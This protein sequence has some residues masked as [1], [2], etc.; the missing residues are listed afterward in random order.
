MI[1]TLPLAPAQ[2]DAMRAALVAAHLPADDLEAEGVILYAF[3]RGDEVVGY[4]GF[5]GYGA[6]ALLRSIVVVPADRRGGLGRQIVASVIAEAGK[7]GA[8]NVYLLTTDAQGYFERLGFVAVERAQAPAS[9]LATRQGAA[10][11]PSSAALLVR[12][13]SR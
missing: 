3:A 11:C 9:I 10:L 7:A 6:S 13:C 12:A 4:G 1:E 2:I 8:E 5:E